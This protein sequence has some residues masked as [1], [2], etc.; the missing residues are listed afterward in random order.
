VTLLYGREADRPAA[1]RA[2]AR[3]LAR[4]AARLVRDAGRS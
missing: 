4:V 2:G 3:P 1:L